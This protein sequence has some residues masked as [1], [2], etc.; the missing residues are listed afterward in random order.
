MQTG[1]TGKVFDKETG[2]P[3]ANATVNLLEDKDVAQT[4][5][6]GYFQVYTQ[7][8]SHKIAPIVV[9]SKKGYKPFQLRINSSGEETSYS[10]KSETEFI[11]YKDTLFMNSNKSSYLLGVDIEKWSQNFAVG[12]TLKIYLTKENV[13]KEVEKIQIELKAKKY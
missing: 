9:V 7:T 1:M 5:N 6:N 11:K 2:K 12:D 8:G 10:V 3:I 13:E 4:D